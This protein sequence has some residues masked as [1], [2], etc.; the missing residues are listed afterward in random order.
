VDQQRGQGVFTRSIAALRQLNGL[1][2]GLPGSSLILNLV[3]N[4][5]GPTLP[6][7]QEE[8]EQDYK[9]ELARRFGVSFNRLYTMTNMPI[10]RFLTELLKRGQ[11]EQYLDLLVNN[12]NPSAVDG[13]MCRHLVSISWDG[14]LFDCD[15]NQML[16]VPVSPCDSQTINAF[17]L[18]TLVQRRIMTGQHCYGCTAG[19][20]SSCGGA[21]T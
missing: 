7:S 17:D 1:G 11:T 6:P 13:L 19:T 2:Y 16:D 21:I 9:E 15:F 5:I 3:Y 8:L 4:P 10:S 18:R 20:G 12:F 14:R